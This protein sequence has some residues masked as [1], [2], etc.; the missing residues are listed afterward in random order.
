M[1]A[2]AVEAEVAR[3][4]SVTTTAAL[5]I[6]TAALVMTAWV[7][8]MGRAHLRRPTAKAGRRQ[9]QTRQA[10]AEAV[11]ASTAT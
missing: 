7:T 8:M 1:V 5:A 11:G 2:V 6:L 9:T 10:K 4:G 3:A